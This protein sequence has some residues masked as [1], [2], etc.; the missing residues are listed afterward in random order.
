[1][2]WLVY[3]EVVDSVSPD[4]IATLTIEVVGLYDIPVINISSLCNK[5]SAVGY[6]ALQRK[7]A[8]LKGAAKA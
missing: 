5:R 1:M 3:S 6:W 4:A 7:A 2:K 8:P